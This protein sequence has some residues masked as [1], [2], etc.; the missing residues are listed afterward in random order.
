MS[1]NCRLL[2]DDRVHIGD[3]D[4]DFCAPSGHSLDDRKLVQIARIIVIYG[5]PYKVPEITRRFLC[6]RRRSANSVE[7]PA[8]LEREIGKKSP[9]KHRPTGNSS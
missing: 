7:L 6:S 9:F 8:C 3:G 2:L 1:V 4:K 5:T